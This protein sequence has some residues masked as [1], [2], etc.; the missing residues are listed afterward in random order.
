[1]KKFIRISDGH[2]PIT[3]ADLDPLM[4]TPSDNFKP[5]E[6]E[7]IEPLQWAKPHFDEVTEMVIEIRPELVEGVFTQQWSIV[8][9]YSEI[10]EKMEA[11]RGDLIK[12]VD[13]EKQARIFS[14]VDAIFPNGL[15]TIQFRNSTDQLA[16]TNVVQGAMANLISGNTSATA[17]FITSDN[18]N[19]TTT[20][21]EMV[22]IGMGALE[23]KQEIVQVARSKKNYLLALLATDD[24]LLILQSYD[25]TTGW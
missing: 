5:N 23:E 1:M 21:A 18:V 2:W 15:K 24:N 6:E 3:E 17:S 20:A 11:L 7:Y 16:L 4:K 22:T 9:K 14:D 10:S 25:A 12:K 8:E 13:E 19:Q